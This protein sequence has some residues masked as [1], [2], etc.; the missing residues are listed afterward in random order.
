MKKI[1]C[2]TLS[3]AMI[4]LVACSFLV[5]R[6]S[7]HYIVDES[8]HALQIKYIYEGGHQ[9]VETITVIPGYHYLMAFFGRVCN[10]FSQ[11]DTGP[12]VGDLRMYQMG[13]SLLFLGVSFCIM[14]KLKMD[15]RILFL[16][17]FMPIIF[18]F[19]FLIYTDIASLT[20]FLIAF[21][22]HLYKRYDLAAVFVLLSIVIRQ[23]NILWTGFFMTLIFFEIYQEHKHF[24][25][26][27]FL[28][29]FDKS[30]AY[31]IVIM[32]FL[33]FYYFND[34]VAIGEK[35]SHPSINVYFG[36]IYLF[37]TVFAFVFLPAILDRSKDILAFFYKRKVLSFAII[38]N[39]FVFFGSTFIVDHPY[40]Q[41]FVGYI[42][43]QIILVMI[44]HFSALL[45]S[46]LL[47]V[48]AIG[49]FCVTKFL[50]KKM[51]FIAAIFSVL[52][53]SMHWMIEF[54]YYM[55]PMTLILFTV[56]FKSSVIKYQVV[57]AFLLSA[58]LFCMIFI[59]GG[60]IL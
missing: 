35:K 13:I 21:L 43:N 31:V 34:G 1:L 26:K 20:V 11:Y 60:F 5:S 23:D 4:I 2:S 22:V 33:L 17:M 49:Y 16:L 3:I 15:D 10:I 47:L 14:R 46:Y 39:G 29:F 40:N 6:F 25:R 51:F 18:P 32:C 56:E 48:L 37:L 24:D 55:I 52:F 58:I 38:A 50:D 28:T 41:S 27:L 54:R 53:L 9:F 19:L 8:L 59:K 57:Y 44:S 42:H 12:K 7:L 45:I 36:N 30:I